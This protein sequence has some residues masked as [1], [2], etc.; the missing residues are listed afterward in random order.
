M[1]F[2]AFVLSRG[3]ALVRFAHAL[4]GD[5][6]HAEDVVQTVLARVHGRWGRV[7]KMAEPEAY[8]KRMIVN[9]HLSWRRRRSNQEVSGQAVTAVP[10][11]DATAAL[12]ER[13]RVWRQLAALPA[14]QRAVLVLRYYEDLPDRDIAAV[15]GCPESTVRSHAARGLAQLRIA[16]AQEGQP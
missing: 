4:N 7:R 14:R 13:D 16:T 12:A 9:E 11:D 1:D 3:A 2:D 5:R 8:V 6:Q 10:S 15:L